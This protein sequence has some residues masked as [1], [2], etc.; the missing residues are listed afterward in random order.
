MG[1]RFEIELPPETVVLDGD[2]TRLAQVI[3]NLIN[4]AAKYTEPGGRIDLRA[5]LDDTGV[6]VSVRDT[7]IGIPADKLAT[8]FEMFSQVEGALSR[9]QGG[10]GIGLYLVK[11]LVEMHEGTIEA[12]SGGPNEGS[13]FVVHL[14]VVAV[15]SAQPRG[16]VDAA[17]VRRSDIMSRARG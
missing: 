15:E 14:P 10:L 8:I 4:N 6:A 1:H 5:T 3:L 9:S 11:R 7:G 17:Q 2:I 12:R 13:E 16:S